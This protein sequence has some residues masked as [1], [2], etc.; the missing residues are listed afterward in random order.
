MR[1]VGRL[2][3]VAMVCVLCCGC[4]VYSRQRF[5]PERVAGTSL[6][7]V[8]KRCGAPD[9]IGGSGDLMVLGY[10]RIEGV[11]VLGL[12]SRVTK[13]TTAVVCD[14]TGRVVSISECEQPGTA[15][16]IIGVGT[17]PVNVTED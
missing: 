14:V 13:R 8:T 11:N 1:H 6:V 5:G 17:S 9:V 4:S 10:H 15:L 2:V 12:Y 7:E 16:T 3:A